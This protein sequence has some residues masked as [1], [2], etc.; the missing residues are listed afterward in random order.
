[1]WRRVE[2]EEGGLTQFVCSAEK[3]GSWRVHTWE[4]QELLIECEGE[5]RL[6]HLPE[7]EL[8]EA[9]NCMGVLDCGEVHHFPAVVPVLQLRNSNGAARQAEQS[10]NL[11]CNMLT[12]GGGA[13]NNIYHHISIHMER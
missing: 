7:E 1:M 6:G 5:Q 10:L 11:N 8:E 13:Y 12:H 3:R 4:C 9:S 2:G